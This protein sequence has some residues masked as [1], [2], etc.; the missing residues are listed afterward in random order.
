MPR[1]L[2]NATPETYFIFSAF[3]GVGIAAGASLIP[4]IDLGFLRM[5]LILLSIDIITYIAMKLG[6]MKT[7]RRRSGIEK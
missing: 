2:R 1:F 7:P 6:W 4:G 3:I 5:L